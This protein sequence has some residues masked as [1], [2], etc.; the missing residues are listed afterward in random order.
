MKEFKTIST[1][2]F[3]TDPFTM[4]GTQWMLIT[5]GDE[6]G[7]NTM[8]ASWG[9]MGVIWN[10]SVAHCYVR[11]T[12]HTLGYLDESAFF[13]L[14]FFS[15]KY[16]DALAYCGKHSGRDGD[17]AKACGLTPVH[18]NGYTYFAEADTVLVCRKLYRQQFDPACF[19]DTA[20]EENNYP[21]KDY[22]YHYIG[23]ITAVLQA[24]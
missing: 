8:T 20:V 18:E 3:T 1:K 4:I 14:S 21:L 11:P 19:I 5:A 22:H 10:K 7:C 13:T 24:K 12:R 23:E 9:A 17:K 2:D 15:E 16:R 6:N